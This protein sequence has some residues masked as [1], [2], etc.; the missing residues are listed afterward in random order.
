[1]PIRWAAGNVRNHPFLN[2][3]TEAIPPA[4][5]L[6]PTMR[7]FGGL[8]PLDS[9]TPKGVHLLP[10]HLRSQPERWH[11]PSSHRRESIV[12]RSMRAYPD[13][14]VSPFVDI[15]LRSFDEVHRQLF[16]GRDIP[17]LLQITLDCCYNR[18]N[19]C[20]PESLP[21][22]PLDPSDLIAGLCLVGPTSVGPRRNHH[23]QHD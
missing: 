23:D 5:R 21:S 20:A 3:I 14:S 22:A 17:T 2:V 1:M 10:C 19:G 8:A 13:P 18:S 15:H 7:R 11:L 9:P 12:A 6:R 16:Y 4:P